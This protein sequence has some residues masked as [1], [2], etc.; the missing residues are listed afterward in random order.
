[1]AEAGLLWVNS[2]GNAA[3]QHYRGSYT[4]AD[5]DL[6]HEFAPDKTTLGF[7]SNP[8]GLTQIV[9]NWDD[10]H[11]GGTQDLDLYL[12]DADGNLIASS[13]NTREGG[14]DPVEQ[15]LYQFDDSRTYFLTINGVSV[16]RALRLD[17]YVH[18][19]SNLELADATG[20]LATP[21][22]AFGAF[23]VGAVFWRTD[24][25]EAY[26]SRGPTADGRVKPDL[27]GP[28]GVASH[29]FAPDRFFGT[30]AAAPHIAGAAALVW[31]AYPSATADEIRQYLSANTIDLLE[32]GVDAAT[33][34]GRLQLPVPPVI[35][36]TATPADSPLPSAPAH[37]AT[38]APTATPRKIVLGTPTG[39]R[40]RPP[41]TAPADRSGDGWIG[42]VAIGL[43]AV[44]AA[45]I[46]WRV[47]RRAPKPI[48]PAATRSASAA[49][50]ACAHC[51]R[52]LPGD[53][54][55]CSQCGRP[56]GGAQTQ[57]RCTRCDRAL[58]P[59]AQYCA[60]CGQ[61]VTAP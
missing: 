33:G 44:L 27:M 14:R 21:G 34:A 7:Q 24:E 39:S 4:D 18:Q 41:I 26:S 52:V 35:E 20:S 51:G 38:S 47:A 1:V 53:A 12:L 19:T 16:D 15:I 59:G 2:A 10:W 48:G 29:V 54:A 32:P 45:I 28:D 5:G 37:T 25:V 57:T 9:L 11:D 49:S 42:L 13:R 3:T 46:G 43:A 50:L 17:L 8:D 6:I 23:T 58:R 61:P 22:D 31:S 60:R 36:P 30:S 56:V 55:F 40:P